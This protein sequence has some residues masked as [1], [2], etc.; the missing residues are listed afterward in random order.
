[1]SIKVI[2]NNQLLIYS[3]K[4]FVT[5]MDCGTRII[6]EKSWEGEGQVWNTLLITLDQCTIPRLRL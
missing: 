4:C 2:P 3:F 5:A 6:Q 1:M